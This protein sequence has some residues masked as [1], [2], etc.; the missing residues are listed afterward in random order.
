M[1]L[2][3]RWP[4]ACLPS[5]AALAG[6]LCGPGLSPGGAGSTVPGCSAALLRE[7]RYCCPDSSLSLSS[8]TYNL[9]S[10]C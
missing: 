1:L 5:A 7:G 3:G 6:R 8:L 2:A 9:L 10:V 4:L